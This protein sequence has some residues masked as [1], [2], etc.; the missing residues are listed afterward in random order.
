MF[1]LLG[2]VERCSNIDNEI[3][4]CCAQ[5]MDGFRQLFLVLGYLGNRINCR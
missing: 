3:A 4:F 2:D 5:V 1:L